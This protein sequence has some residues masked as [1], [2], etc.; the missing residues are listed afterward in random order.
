MLEIEFRE[1]ETWKFPQT[2]NF[3]RKE[4]VRLKRTKLLEKSTN[5]FSKSFP[6]D[7]SYDIANHGLVKQMNTDTSFT[8]FYQKK[9]ASDRESLLCIGEIV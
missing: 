8:D 3:V 2:Y 7:G 9:N 4:S 5:D 6:N 1:N